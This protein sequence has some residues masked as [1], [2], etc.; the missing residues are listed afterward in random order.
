MDT[1]IMNAFLGISLLFL[2]F[3]AYI[4]WRILIIT[5]IIARSTGLFLESL[6]KKSDSKSNEEDVDNV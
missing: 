2:I 3:L 6:V 1:W 5:E 4:N